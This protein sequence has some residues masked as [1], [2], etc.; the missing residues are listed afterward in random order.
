VNKV[1]D[2]ASMARTGYYDI[3]LTSLNL[4][5]EDALTI[6]AQLRSNDVTRH[7]PIVFLATQADTA[8]IAKGLD[9]GG[10]D[11]V[12][13]PLDANEIIAR[14]RTQLRHKKHY[15]SLRKNYE[16]SLTL[17]LVD[18][19]TGAFNRRY[20]EAHLPR[21]LERTAQSNKE[22]S[23]LMIDIDHF[24]AFNDTHGHAVGDLVLKSIVT[25]ILNGVRPSDLVV[26]LGGEEFVVIMPETPMATAMMVA[27]R[28]RKKIA[29]EPMQLGEGTAPLQV[30]VSMGCAG[31][32]GHSVG[33]EAALIERADAA[34]YK[35][36]NEGRN[37]VVAG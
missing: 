35:A 17:S 23:A 25:R 2:A 8:K 30:T 19:L 31:I 18:P 4:A 21:M 22:L 12:L 11:Y 10:N 13:R 16:T 9:L 36:K 28:L 7:I 27:E 5:Q 3:V 37:R 6:C 20:M 26:R 1:S 34:L 29:A 32:T 15:D 14:T 24:K 33:T